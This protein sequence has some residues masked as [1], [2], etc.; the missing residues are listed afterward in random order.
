M[1][2]TNNKRT[3][4]IRSLCCLSL[5][6]KRKNRGKRGVKREHCSELLWEKHMKTVLLW[7]SWER[8]LNYNL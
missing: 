6:I 7:E 4:N 5:K 3:K 2:F 8:V 1:T